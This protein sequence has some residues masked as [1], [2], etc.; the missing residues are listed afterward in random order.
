MLK[1]DFGVMVDW[2]GDNA[3][4]LY[5]TNDYSKFVSGLCG[6][7]NGDESDDF[8]DPDFHLVTIAIL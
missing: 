7:F 2:D 1:T 8:T 5:L 6:F 3:V 4:R